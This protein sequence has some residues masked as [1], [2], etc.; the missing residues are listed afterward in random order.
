MLELQFLAVIG[1]TGC[2]A[3][4]G[5]L[6]MNLVPQNSKLL[7]CG[8]RYIMSTMSKLW[9][10]WRSWTE[11]SQA[12]WLASHQFL[13]CFGM[14]LAEA[15]HKPLPVI[16]TFWSDQN[17]CWMQCMLG[18]HCIGMCIITRTA[19]AAHLLTHEWAVVADRISLKIVMF[20]TSM[21]PVAISTI[22]AATST[23][24]TFVDTHTLVQSISELMM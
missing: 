20:E 13:W 18:S 24:S 15:L 16:V 9:T 6:I 17:A 12:Y 3:A 2:N 10:V 5:L 14:C 8:T 7:H 4:S 19:T 1:Y 23:L 22:T 11:L 21:I